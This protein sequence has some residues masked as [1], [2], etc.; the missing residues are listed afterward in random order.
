MTVFC[1]CSW[2]YFPRRGT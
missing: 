2:W 1:C